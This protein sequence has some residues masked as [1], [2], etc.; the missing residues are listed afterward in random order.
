MGIQKT[1]YWVYEDG[2]FFE[3]HMKG[4]INPLRH[5][6]L[7]PAEIEYLKNGLKNFEIYW[8]D[9]CLHRIDGPVFRGRKGY[10][11]RFYL[12]GVN[13]FFEEWIEKVKDNISEEKYKELVERYG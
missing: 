2:G 5:N 13:Y 1:K 9:G 8:Q 3:M 7:G 4:I 12:H 6:H 10:P 11:L